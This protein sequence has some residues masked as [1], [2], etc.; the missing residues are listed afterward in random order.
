MLKF[1]QPFPAWDYTTAKGPTN[2]A[3][4]CDTFTRAAQYAYQ[5]PI[6]LTTV[7]ATVTKQSS[8]LAMYYQ[9]QDY[10]IVR[11]TQS[12][13][14]VPNAAISWIE[15]NGQT[16]NLTDIHFHLPSE[17]ILDGR[18]YPLEVHLVHRNAQRQGVVIAVFITLTADE[19][20]V[21]MGN[22][23]QFGDF[24]KFNVGIF[25]P[26]IRQAIQYTGTL[27]TP[28]TRGPVTWLVMTNTLE[29]PQTWFQYLKQ[30][31]PLKNNARPVQPQ[32]GRPIYLRD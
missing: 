5:S 17:H 1:Q 24:I 31:A 8:Q 18:T 2:W 21:P 14:L 12:V 19:L 7:Q 20:T 26:Q 27:T 11:F 9:A 3:H 13:H 23:W 22:D 15:L 10:Q 4:L 30:Q 32:R 29:L 6:A 25:L 16:Y 28:P